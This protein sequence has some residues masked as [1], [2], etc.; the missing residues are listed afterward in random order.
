MKF[1]LEI[2]CDNDAFEASPALEISR[3]LESVARR[4]KYRGL[5]D[6]NKV[7][8]ANGNRVGQWTYGESK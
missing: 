8:D 5:E 3:I 4:I 2:A 1:T 7:F 6:S